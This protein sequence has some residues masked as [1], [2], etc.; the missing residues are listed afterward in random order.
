[1]MSHPRTERV[2]SVVSEDEI[3]PGL[4]RIGRRSVFMRG[5]LSVQ[6]ADHAATQDP[7]QGVRRETAIWPCQIENI[8]AAAALLTF[9]RGK[10]LDLLLGK[11]QL[12][13]LSDA[14]CHHP[15]WVN[16]TLE[17]TWLT[18]QLLL[19]L[20]QRSRS[21]WPHLPSVSIEQQIA[22]RL[23]EIFR[24]LNNFVDQRIQTHSD[25][26]RCMARDLVELFGPN[27]GDLDIR[28][29][30]ERRRLPELQWHALILAAAHLIMRALLNGFRHRSGGA[31]TVSLC[32]IGPHCVRLTIADDGC[33]ALARR[34]SNEASVLNG[35]THLMNASLVQRRGTQN[36]SVAQIT[37]RDLRSNSASR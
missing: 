16:E 25:L 12:P 19:L 34:D 1:M 4:V 36:G 33:D 3:P 30:I 11:T 20:D 31:I 17:R 22:Q 2:G 6:L 24:V 14:R 18:V 28:L 35:L 8:A 21:G 23:A 9:R 26:L 10:I 29:N 15:V 27:I 37:M 5:L 13:L 32:A 7:R